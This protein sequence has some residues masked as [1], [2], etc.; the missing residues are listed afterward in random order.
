MCTFFHVKIFKLNQSCDSNVL[1]I[2]FH[3][4]SLR[5]VRSLLTAHLLFIDMKFVQIIFFFHLK[6]LLFYTEMKFFCAFHRLERLTLFDKNKL[7]KL[8]HIKCRNFAFYNNYRNCLH[9]IFLIVIKQTKIKFL[10][11]HA[12]SN[13]IAILLKLY[14][15]FSNQQLFSLMLPA[16]EINCWIDI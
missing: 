16:S 11:F 14:I 5:C 4:L 3:S 2:Q 12:L 1:L 15:F 8:L 9:Q 6:K 13:T 7:K 10:K